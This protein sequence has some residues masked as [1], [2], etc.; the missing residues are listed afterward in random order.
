MTTPAIPIM[1]QI[2][3]RDVNCYRT[4]PHLLLILYPRISPHPDKRMEGGQS[5][6]E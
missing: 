6:E 4:A 3:R 5:H 1:K 2:Q